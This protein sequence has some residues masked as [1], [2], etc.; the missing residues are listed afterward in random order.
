VLLIFSAPSEKAR[1]LFN[2]TDIKQQRRKG[3]KGELG[4]ET[5]NSGTSA[6]Q[7]H[8]TPNF[9]GRPICQSGGWIRI[10]IRRPKFEGRKPKVDSEW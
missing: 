1:I 6:S 10:K 5:F 9:E 4:E 3:T 2:D 8:S 7:Q